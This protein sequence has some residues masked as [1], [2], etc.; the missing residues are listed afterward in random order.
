MPSVGMRRTTRVFGMVK[1]SEGARVLR[2]GRRLWPDSGEVNTK[3]PT[4]E[5]DEHYNLR[6][7]PLKSEVNGAA[8]ELN[9]KPKRVLQVENPK[10]QTRKPKDA[11]I[12]NGGRVD[13]MY[14]IVYTR[15][16]KRNEV[17]KDQL[18]EQKTFERRNAV[19][20]NHPS[21]KSN[22]K[23]KKVRRRV[24]RRQAS[25]RRKTS[26]IVQEARVLTF[27]VENGGCY[28][29][30]PSFLTSVLAYVRRAEVSLSQLAAF[31]TSQ[32]IYG[33]YTSNG[34]NFLWGPPANRTGICKFF[35][36]RESIPLFSVDFSAVPHCFLYMYHS[37]LHRFKCMQLVPVNSDETMSDS[38]DELSLT[39]VVD[40]FKTKIG[41]AAVEIG[42]LGSKI[43]LHPTDRGSRLTGRNGYRNGLSSRGIQKR[44]SSLRRRRAKNLSLVSMHKANGALMSD[45]ISSRRNGIPFSSVVSK[46]KVRSSVRHSSAANLS[47]MSSSISDLMQNVDLSKCSANVLVIES[48]RCYREEGTIITLEL[49]A[50][51]EWLLV[52]QKDGSTKYAHKADKFMRPSSCNRFTHA[53]MWTGDENWKLEFPNRR[54]WIIFKD[55]YKECSERNTPA[56]IVKVIPVPGVRE[57]SGYEDRCIVPFHRPELYITFDGDEVSR[58]LAKRKANYDMDSEDEEWLKKFNYEFF[59]GNGHCEHLSNDCFELMVDAFEKAHFCSPDDY[60]NENASTHLCRDLASRGV[61]EA[62][63]AYWLKKR[64]QRRSALLRVFQGHQVKKAPVVP[65]PFLRKRRSFKRQASHGRGKHP[66]LLKALAAEHD[67]LAEQNAMLKVEE[68]RVSASRSVESAIA[69]RRR[70]QLLMENADMATYKA[71]MALGIAEAAQFTEFSDGAVSQYLDL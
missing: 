31:L 24:S 28:G 20:K 8:P 30:F 16:R 43:I 51:R 47:D 35:G 45:L 59:S 54:D 50:S 69:K 23:K 42:N 2:S 63:H 56:S 70:A 68:A 39:Y 60:A 14:G 65:K 7:K 21:G 26:K 22:R 64:K 4:K 34:V 44:R 3:T 55:L 40:A 33:V 62:V 52:V 25:K 32:P 6:K 61:V 13:K 29:W 58:A 5:A 9:G 18:S 66:S 27:T 12:N 10:K 57:V 1:G 71:M 67:A 41:T 46:N 17:Q 19:Q 49:S 36:V 37:K 38:E 53:I 15:K 11:A 48:D